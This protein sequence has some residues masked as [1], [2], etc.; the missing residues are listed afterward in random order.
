MKL[1]VRR[2][3]NQRLTGELLESRTRSASGGPAVRLTAVHRTS[4]PT[5]V[6]PGAPAAGRPCDP[7]A[8]IAPA[9]P[10][11]S[12]RERWRRPGR[13]TH[14]RPSHQPPHAGRTR[15]AGDDPAVRVGPVRANCIPAGTTPLDR[16]RLRRERR[17]R[18]LSSRPIRQAHGSRQILYFLVRINE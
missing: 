12:Y 18:L 16:Q 2:I 14:N 13:A 8:S 5:P 11:R 6:V 10:R 17:V 3:W 4:H 15:S 1:G 9:T 7:Q